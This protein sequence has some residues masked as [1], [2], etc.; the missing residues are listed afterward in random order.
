[1][2]GRPAWIHE[3]FMLPGDDKN[4]PREEERFRG[5]GV[6]EHRKS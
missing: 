6:T 4:L 1:M 3:Q 5:K 2:R